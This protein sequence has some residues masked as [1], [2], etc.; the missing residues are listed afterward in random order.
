MKLPKTSFKSRQ[1]PNVSA[2]SMADIAFL[3]LIF[4]LVTTT[5]VQDKGLLVKLPMWVPDPPA[6]SMNE[7][8]VLNILINADDAILSSGKEIKYE[9]LKSTIVEFIDNPQQLSTMPIQPNKAIISLQND[10][11]TTYATYL[12]VY[13]ETKAAYMMLWENEAQSIYGMSYEKC[14]TADKKLIRSKYPQ[15]ISEAEPT[16]FGEEK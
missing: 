7:R 8:N 4:F 14:S 11:G 5:I 2:G 15:V 13:S 1:N 10:R 16:D 3:L 12:K 9:D 6:V